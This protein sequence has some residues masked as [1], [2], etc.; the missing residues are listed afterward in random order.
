MAQNEVVRRERARARAVA[1][2]EKADLRVADAEKNLK[3]VEDQVVALEKRRVKMEEY[4]DQMVE[5][6]G[7]QNDK[8]FQTLKPKK[9][10]EVEVEVEV[11]D[12]DVE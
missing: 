8:L 2:T 9:E 12:G 6:L 11:D 3:K 5:R 1:L 4:R 7:N 10:L